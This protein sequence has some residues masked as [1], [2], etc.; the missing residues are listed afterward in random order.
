MG[1]F[2]RFLVLM[3]AVTSLNTYASIQPWQNISFISQSFYEIA[4]GSEY[5]NSGHQIR[6][7]VK[8]IKIY[9]QH[10][11]G[12]SQLQN[13]LIDA[14][15]THLSNITGLQIRRVKKISHANLKFFFTNQ[16]NLN[17]LSDRHSGPSVA[18]V[19]TQKTCIANI[20][21]NRRSEVYSAQIYVPVDFAY[22]N[23]SLVGCIVEELT[24][25]LGLPRDSEKV[26]PSIF[27]DKSTDQ[28][29]TGLDE[30]LIR[31]LYNPRIKAGMRKKTLSR[32][33][34]TVIKQLSNKGYISSAD[35]RLRKTKLY[36]ML[37]Y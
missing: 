31:I 7:W 36:A 16:K 3:I 20:K 25:V 28:L 21:L 18:K 5:S 19:N 9:V 23:G 30:T 33:L 15:I 11:V 34:A 1:L 10:D 8:P 2:S 27:N 13:Q 22:R 35:R 14:H 12:D 6:K 4:L 32:V 24:Q 17:R 26:Y 29:L 37:G